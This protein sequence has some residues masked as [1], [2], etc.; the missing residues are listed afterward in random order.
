MN[1]LTAVVTKLLS[2][3]YQKYANSE[4]LDM[5]NI[6]IVEFEYDCWGAITQSKKYFTSKTEANKFKVGS[7]ITV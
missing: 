4:D 5:K 2:E 1:T 7:T 3:P 6:W